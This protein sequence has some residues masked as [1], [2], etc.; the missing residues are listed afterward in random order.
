MSADPR[1]A[2]PLGWRHL[3]IAVG[4][5]ALAAGL[6]LRVRSP[7]V[8]PAAV[9][10]ET[11]ARAALLRVEQALG[12]QA[13]ALEPAAAAAAR[14]PELTAALSMGADQATV[15]DLL[16]NEDWWATYR[17]EFPLS[18]VLTEIPLA[19]VGPGAGHLA[20]STLV[21]G[22]RRRGAT[23]SGLLPGEG[24]A[25]VAATAPVSLRA[26][27]RRQPGRA[28]RDQGGAKDQDGDGGPETTPVVLLGKLVDEKMLQKVADLT[29]DLVGLSDGS[30]LIEAGGHREPLR[31]LGGLVGH[32]RGAPLALGAGWIGAATPIDGGGQFIVVAS[33][34]A[35]ATA[36]PSAATEPTPTRAALGLWLVV[37][38]GLSLGVGVVG[39]VSPRRRRRRPGARSEAQ[40][41]ASAGAATGSEM[42]GAPGADAGVA[43]AEPGEASPRAITLPMPSSP[44]ATQTASASEPMPGG[45]L[46]MG[47]YELI[48]RIGEGGMAEIFFAVARGAE[49]FVRHFVVKRMHPQ[50]ARSREAVNQFIDEARLQSAL[51]HSNIVPVFD[52]GKAGG[53]Y[54]L[55]L[56]YIHGRDLGQLV[57]MHVEKLGGPMDVAP[58]FFVVHEVLEA[59]AYAHGQT[60]KDGRPLEIVHR[61]VS[62]GNVLVSYQGEIKLTDFGIA[63][64]GRRVSRTEAGMV[65]GNASFMSPEQARGE[66]VDHRSDLFCAGLVMFYCLTGQLLYRGET[67][68]NRL[69]RAAAGPAT[70]QFGQIDHLPL[71][72]A[73]VLRRA[74]AIEPG[75]RYA[76]A[77][78]FARDLAA[79]MS[80]RSELARI[81]DVLFPPGQRRD[82]RLSQQHLPAPSR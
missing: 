12:A 38:G 78:E 6:G 73:K 48:E 28:G 33:M 57:Q 7:A 49:N 40:T 39:S 71:P 5:L 52:F 18:A 20:T 51:V 45:P 43:A 29:G 30:R 50:L 47:R 80:T 77:T 23:T 17:T 64:A 26:A 27:P 56:E 1:P 11:P 72:A 13:R 9:D 79:T 61:D 16:D 66:T 25:F 4:A 2:R 46:R 55:A 31:V 76:S 15:Q 10:L 67:T 42:A 70:S 22:G 32:E 21:Q 34:G 60:A 44:S 68:L 62:P 19:V 3:G 37:A 36:G 35:A 53:E 63:K 74:L 58:A 41:V 24:R 75:R 82:L 69:L 14:L 65:K 59:L 81:M 54:F 8:A